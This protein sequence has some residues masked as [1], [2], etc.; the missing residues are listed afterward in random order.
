MDIKSFIIGASSNPDQPTGTKE[1][2]ENGLH[3][4]SAYAQAD[5]QVQGTQPTGKVNI[6]TTEE[7][8]VTEYAT[9]QVTD[10]DLVA[11]NILK[12]VNILGV[13]GSL[14]IP[15][16]PTGTVGINTNGTHDVK[17]YASA[18]VNVANTYHNSDNGKVVKNKQLVAQ[19]AYPSTITENGSYNTTEYNS[20]TVSVSGGGAPSDYIE[21]AEYDADYIK[22]LI[23]HCSRRN[24]SIA[25][26]AAPYLREVVIAEYP[27]T[28]L[29]LPSSAFQSCYLTSFTFPSTAT[30]ITIG[31]YAFYSN[32]FRT[33]TLPSN[34]KSIYS[35]A[36]QG[37]SYLTEVT[38]EG[39]PTTIYNSVFSNC[40]NLTDIYVPWSQGDVANAPWGA[41]N[42]TIHYNS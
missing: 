3:D 16:E 10:A 29:V 26:R 21:I 12:D 38:F 11:E 13:T 23:W 22:K 41:T 39:T 27:A 1:I 17:E 18:E 8:D 14:E 31:E 28:L 35:G 32:L 33:I 2:T 40:T 19:S 30:S 36:F 25:Y 6:T 24:D 15:E 34:I 42:A 7:V 5:V 37:C 4:V 9:A 20:V